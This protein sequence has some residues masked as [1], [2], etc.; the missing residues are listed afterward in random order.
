MITSLGFL[1]NTESM[2]SKAS[3]VVSPRWPA[4]T[5]GRTNSRDN[6]DG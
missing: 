2:R 3:A 5:I 6:N 1:F 4:L